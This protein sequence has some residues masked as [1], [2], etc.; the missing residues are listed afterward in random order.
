LNSFALQEFC[1]NHVNLNHP[2]GL[3]WF[4]EPN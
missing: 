2:C 3:A 4:L 1:D